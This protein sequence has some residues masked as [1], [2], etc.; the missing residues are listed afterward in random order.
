MVV[1]AIGSFFLRGVST[2]SNVIPKDK[3]TK[4]NKQEEEDEPMIY[5]AFW[6]EQSEIDRLVRDIQNDVMENIQRQL[7]IDDINF[8]GKLSHSVRTGHDGRFKTVE[9]A[10]PY[11][12]AVE[13]GLPAGHLISFSALFDW[14]KGKLKISDDDEAIAVTAK[15]QQKILDKGIKPRRFL[16]KAIL[17]LGRRNKLVANRLTKMPRVKPRKVQLPHENALRVLFPHLSRKLK[18][19]HGKNLPARLLKYNKRK[20][21]KKA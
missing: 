9:V 18:A 3:L 5:P 15:I 11:G 16:K 10:S 17:M 8:T 13:F 7:V 1:S 21:K 12:M 20:K 19:K 2:A 4:N 6:M 14:V